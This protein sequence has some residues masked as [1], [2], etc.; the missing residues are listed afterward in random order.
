MFSKLAL[1]IEG[2]FTDVF[3]HSFLQFLKIIL[4][5]ILLV[6][7]FQMYLLGNILFEIG[8]S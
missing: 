1:K 8:N 5:Y 6:R 3:L 7:L 2:P 4:F